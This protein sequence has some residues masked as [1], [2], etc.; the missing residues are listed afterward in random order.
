MKLLSFAA[1]GRRSFGAVAGGG[2]VDLGARLGDTYAD[3][4]ALL[5]AGDAARVAAAA[6]ATA[7]S[8]YALHQISYLPPISRPEKIFC[9]GVNYLNRNEE[10]RDASEAPAH[11]SIFM[12]TPASLVGHLAPIVRPPESPQL[13]YEGEIV[14]VIGKA[15]RRIAPADARAH[16]AGL[17]CMNEGT[18]RDWVRHG[19]FNVTQGKN[20]VASGAVGPWIVTA[21]EFSGYDDLR[22]TTRVNGEV[23]QNDTT[24]SLAFPFDYLISYISTFT[25]LGPGDVIATGTPTGAGARF[26]PPRYLVPGD[27]VEVEVR[28]VGTLSNTVVDETGRGV[29][30][31][32]LSDTHMQHERLVVPG[33]DLLIHAGDATM[34]GGAGDV[35]A[36]YAWLS[37]QP[38]ERIVFVPGNHDFGFV[39][40]PDFEGE[41][42]RRW[43]RVTTLLDEPATVAGH[44]IWG[45]PWQPWFHDWAFNF[46]PEPGG[47]TQARD[48]WAEIPNNVEILVTHGP[49]RGVLDEATLGGHV[50]L[51]SPE[52][53][54][55]ATRTPTSPRVRSHS[56]GI[57]IRERRIRAS[58]QRGVVRFALPRDASADRRRSRKRRRARRSRP[59]VFDRSARIYFRR[60]RRPI[61]RT[62]RRSNVATTSS[63]ASANAR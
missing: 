33:G 14:I 5:A 63:R 43:P 32:A 28:G 41:L 50:G 62:R 46:A 30:I 56:R 6:C 23:R 53:A 42:A 13:D 55:R 17:T 2:I 45:S 21:D 20:F 49:M 24:A 35:F 7:T 47:A 60:A 19:K 31:V 16:I 26:D 29:R 25:T 8:D 22:V 15:G 59:N 3:L 11:P 54:N 18:I 27:V 44:S 58:R 1:N 36:T 57:R 61:F 9:I 10:Y 51:P 4:H 38:H 52:R 37:M 48:K 40:D 34:H 39:S 12:R